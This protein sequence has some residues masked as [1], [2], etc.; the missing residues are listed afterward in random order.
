MEP[1]G[2]FPLSTMGWRMKR[3]CSEVYP[4]ILIRAIRDSGFGEGGSLLGRAAN[5]SFRRL[6]HSAYG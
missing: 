1:S 6:S 2:S 4:N 5:S 3:R